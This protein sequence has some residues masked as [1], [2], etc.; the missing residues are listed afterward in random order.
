MLLSRP[1]IVETNAYAQHDG[2]A[3]GVKRRGRR[4]RPGDRPRR[5]CLSVPGSSPR[6]L[7][8]AASLNAD[9]VLLDLEDSVAP[10]AKAE[11]RASV[12]SALGQNGWGGKVITVRVN[13]ATTPWAYRDVI[14]ITERAGQHLDT[15]VLPKVSGPR[16][17]AWL[18]LL[19]GQVEQAVGLPGGG[20]G[21]EAQIEDAPGLACVEEI[22]GC[23][24]RL[25]A[26]VFGPA[27][28]MASVGM[29]SLQIGA[30][31]AGYAGGDAFHYAHLRILVAARAHG[32]QAIDG[33]YAAIGDAEGL[34]ASAASAAALGYDGKW[35]IHPGQIETVN[36]AFSPGQEEYDRAELILEAYTYY[37]SVQ[38]R[39]AARL[40]GEMIDEA[41]RKLALVAAAR[42]R[43]AGLKR[44]SAF[45]PPA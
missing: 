40:D 16:Q 17:V 29:R 11:A 7:A 15:I 2:K 23:C 37:T 42:G 43:A 34:R 32:L 1:G 25:E 35:V 6:F 8:K 36:A 41:S 4:M 9:Q 20:I 3:L 14:E 19:L 21:I 18:D 10:D 27:D 22:A 28:F 30:Q 24:A 33:P 12:A 5:S 39:G 38:G 45:R 26:L 44:T 31:P 13:G